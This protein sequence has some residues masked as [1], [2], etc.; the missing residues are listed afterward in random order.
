M[1]AIEAESKKIKKKTH[2]LEFSNAYGMLGPIQ[3]VN[4]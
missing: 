2:S 4:R 3:G 1:T